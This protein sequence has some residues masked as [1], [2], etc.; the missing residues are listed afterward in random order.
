MT[1]EDLISTLQDLA[2]S[3][4]A[5]GVPAHVVYVRDQLGGD[6]IAARTEAETL[7]D[8]SEVNNIILRTE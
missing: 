1:L 5:D 2:D 4:A 3:Y 6:I 7:S 8:G